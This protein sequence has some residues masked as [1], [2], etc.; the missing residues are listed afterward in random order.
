MFVVIVF[1]Q[2]R[3]RELDQRSVI[4]SLAIVAYVAHLYVRSIP[5][6]GNDPQGEPVRAER[7]ELRSSR[8]DGRGTAELAVRRR[9]RRGLE[10]AGF[11]R[12][13]WWAT[14]SWGVGEDGGLRPAASEASRP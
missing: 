4:I 14:A 9:S 12:A 8:L 10:V 3:E 6:A 2:A 7:S 13:S 5:T 1:R 11:C